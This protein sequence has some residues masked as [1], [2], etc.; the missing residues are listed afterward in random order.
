MENHPAERFKRR[1]SERDPLRSNQARK[2]LAGP[3]VTT[4]TISYVDLAGV[5]RSKP[6]VNADVRTVLRDGFKTARANLDMNVATPLTPGTRLDISQGDVSIIPDP[7]TLVFPSYAPGTARMIGD[8]HEPDGSPSPFCART[9][10]RTALLKLRRTGFEAEVGLESEFHLVR[11]DGEKVVPTDLSG[12]QT[13]DGYN[14]HREL[15]EEI[16]KALSTVGVRPVKVH[17]EGGRGQM[18]IDMQ[19]QP[20]MVTADGYGYFKEVVR[21]VS[22]KNG[23]VASF[24][25]KIGADWWG[26]GLHVHLSL[27]NA[28]KGNVFAGKDDPRKLGLSPVCYHF[29]GGVLKHVRALCAVAAPTVNSYKRLLPGRWNADAV[30][31]GPGNRGAAV[32]IPDE[33]KD[34]TR[35]ELRVP[36][37][38]C[39]IYL[40]LTC[41]L[42]AGMDGIQRKLDPGDPLLFDASRMTDRERE[43]KGLARMPRSLGEALIEFERD[44]L[45]RRTLGSALV[46]EF[47][48]QRYYEDSQAA[49]QVTTW[50]VSHFLDL[51]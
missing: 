32:R 21:A 36:D 41:L 29:I 23:C 3:G 35:M 19:H 18:E 22:R 1:F 26:S 27:R 13:L 7:D 8:I 17:T 48:A 31:Y 50:E 39:N 5:S 6:L 20:A 15:L 2:R 24:M 14:Q 4:V 33:R 12:I 37:N 9:L 40:L 43:S 46:E 51:F 28:K 49:D 34:A 45:M 47:L 10:L 44:V 38:S 11:L 16:V 25:P 42:A 30:A